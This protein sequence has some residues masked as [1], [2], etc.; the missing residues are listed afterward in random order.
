MNNYFK[1]WKMLVKDWK[2]VIFYIK[3]EVGF[4][5][6]SLNLL[7]ISDNKPGPTF[8]W[9]ISALASSVVKQFKCIFNR[10]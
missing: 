1:N 8:R 5:P 6:F 2:K 3:G 4:T 7:N 10:K 9:F